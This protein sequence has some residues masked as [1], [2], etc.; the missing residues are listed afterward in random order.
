VTPKRWRKI[1]QEN[2][3]VG[4]VRAAAILPSGSKL[5]DTF[6]L[7]FRQRAYV[8]IKDTNYTQSL[9]QRIALAAIRMHTTKKK[10]QEKRKV[11]L[12]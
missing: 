9:Q 2:V 12:R 4:C 11:S 6:D 1:G 8:N 7:I 10:L 3:R 5:A